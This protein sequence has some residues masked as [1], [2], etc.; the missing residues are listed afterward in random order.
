[1]EGVSH[2]AE[3]DSANGAAG[4]INN[5]C[6]WLTG[7]GEGESVFAANDREVEGGVGMDEALIGAEVSQA[8]DRISFEKQPAG[9]AVEAE[10]VVAEFD[11]GGGGAKSFDREAAGDGEIAGAEEGFGED[12]DFG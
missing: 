5:F 10:A 12:D 8:T 11:A 3:S 6:H 7:D 2:G 9:L 1:M 4:G